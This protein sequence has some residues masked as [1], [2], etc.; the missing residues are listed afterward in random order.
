MR[1]RTQPSAVRA[2]LTL[3]E[4]LRE[5]E[6]HV[7]RARRTHIHTYTLTV[8]GRERVQLSERVSAVIRRESERE[9]VQRAWRVSA[10]VAI[11]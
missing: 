11:V 8:G 1:E 7:R 6:V 3:R 10:S 2:A 4:R 9:R 5:D